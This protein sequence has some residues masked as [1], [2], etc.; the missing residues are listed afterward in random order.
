MGAAASLP[1]QSCRL[2]R[3]RR[4]NAALL[5]RRRVRASR[6]RRRASGRV[7]VSTWNVGGVLP[8]GDLRL[9]DWLDAET[10]TT[11][12]EAVPLTPKNVISPERRPLSRWNSLIKA[13]LNRSSS[14]SS[15]FSSQ[16]IHPVKDG[17]TPSRS[18]SHA[19]PEFL[20]VASKQMV[21]ILVSVWVRSTL[22]RRL[23]HLSVSS[24]GC[25]VMGFMGNKGSVSVSFL[26]H[27][28]SFCFVCCH[29]ASGG[30][31]GDE[32]RRNCDAGKILSW[33]T[34]HLNYRVS[35]PEAAARNLARKKE[36]GEL[37][38]R[39]QLPATYKYYR[40]SDDYY[41]CVQG[42][43]GE[44]KRAPAWCDRILWRGM[45]LSRSDMI[46]F[47]SRLSDHRPVRA[48][49]V[50]EVRED[51]IRELPGRIPKARGQPL[52]SLI[53]SPPSDLLAPSIHKCP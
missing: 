17:P 29:L 46:E 7:F 2:A 28:T 41:G 5:H 1:A 49:F 43:K 19:S 48:V 52:L 20:C 35:L 14:S 27:N 13:A 34:F 39:D 24:V 9:D 44:N 40:N 4:S 42:R 53:S 23:H 33:T 6:S 10:P 11:F 37:L 30:K 50:A 15:Y 12:Q 51:P 25:G 36:W 16:K 18:S 38:Q 45:G 3:S 22:R 32:R 26:L 21:G 47:E 8:D 31:E